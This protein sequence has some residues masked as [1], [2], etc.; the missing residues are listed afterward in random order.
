MISVLVFVRACLSGSVISLIMPSTAFS[1]TNLSHQ[2]NEFLVQKY[3]PVCSDCSCSNEKEKIQFK[4]ITNQIMRNFCSEDVKLLKLENVSSRNLLRWKKSEF[5][6]GRPKCHVADSQMNTGSLRSAAFEPMC[7]R[8]SR[9]GNKWFA[10]T[11]VATD[12]NIA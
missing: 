10:V 7:K 9:W 8:H 6:I 1:G 5:R 11:T 3:E 4:V 12:E 2:H